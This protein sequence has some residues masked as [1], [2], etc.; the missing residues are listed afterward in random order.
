MNVCHVLLTRRSVVITL[1]YLI[2]LRTL[3][4]DILPVSQNKRQRLEEVKFLQITYPE[5]SS[6]LSSKRWAF[7]HSITEWNSAQPHAVAHL[8]ALF[9]YIPV[10]FCNA[11]T[12]PVLSSVHVWTPTPVTSQVLSGTQMGK[13]GGKLLQHVTVNVVDIECHRYILITQSCW[14]KFGNICV[15]TALESQT[16][17]NLGDLVYQPPS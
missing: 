3:Q 10:R 2:H 7:H 15:I 14:L 11:C 12:L 1:S 17:R 5:S 4:L 9:T 8:S 16:G 13:V 6:H